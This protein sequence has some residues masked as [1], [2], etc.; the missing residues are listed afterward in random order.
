MSTTYG[1]LTPRIGAHA[2]K[3]MLSHAEPILVLNKLGQAKPM[4]RNTGETIKFRR[5]VPLPAALTPLTEGVTPAASDFR[6]EDVEATLAEYGDWTEL[7]NKITDLHE[8][9]VGKNMAMILGEQAAETVEMITY[10]VIKAGTNVIYGGGVGARADIA[11]SLSIG[12]QRKAVRTLRANRAKKITSIL[13]GSAM[14]ST[15]PIEAAFVAVTHTDNEA[16]IRK[17]PNFTPVAEYGSRQPICPE[18]VGS[19]EDVRYITSPLFEP[20]EAAGAAVGTDGF[21]SSDDTNNDVYPVLYMGREAFGMIALKGSKAFGGAIKPMVR[22]PGKPDSNDPMA[23]TGSVAWK[24]WYAAKILNDSWMVRVE[25][26]VEEDP[27]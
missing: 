18:E 14:I 10:G 1:D 26:A 21:I 5:P 7:T 17:L 9:P 3:E 6:Y 11:S 15:T 25:V 27:S 19:V 8:D 22:N 16:A 20:F 4:P 13:G 24:T 2:E 12:D 23:R